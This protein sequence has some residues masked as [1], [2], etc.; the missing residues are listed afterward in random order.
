VLTAGAFSALLE[1]LAES[2]DLIIVDSAPLLAVSDGVPLLSAVD[3]VLLVS[4]I[5]LTTTTAVRHLNDLLRRVHHVNILG[6]VANNLTDSEAGYGA[7]YGY[8]V[9]RRR[10][11]W[12]R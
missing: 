1:N 2:N 12:R 8:G 10:R 7:A 6:V 5:G 4:R 9:P 11:L 3:G